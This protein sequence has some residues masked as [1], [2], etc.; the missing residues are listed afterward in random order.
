MFKNDLF[1][2]SMATLYLLVYSVF[3][4]FEATENYAWI[5]WLLSPFVVGGLVYAVLK[6][7]KYDGPD[8]QDKEFGY[9]DKNT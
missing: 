9:Q 5:M 3:L 7:G 6:F 4:Q 2:V 8:L 1:W